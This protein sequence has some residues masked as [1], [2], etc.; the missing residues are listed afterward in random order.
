[1][2]KLF[3]INELEEKGETVYAIYLAKPLS[4]NNIRCWLMWKGYKNYEEYSSENYLIFYQEEV[5]MFDEVSRIYRSI[6]DE[7]MFTDLNENKKG[8]KFR[9][10][11]KDKMVIVTYFSQI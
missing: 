1:M 5:P 11:E 4:I 8:F 2:P 7:E 3:S 10:Y 6:T 9:V